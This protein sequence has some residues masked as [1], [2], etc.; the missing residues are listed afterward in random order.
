MMTLISLFIGAFLAAT[1]LPFSSEVMLLA[2]LTAGHIPVVILVGVAASGNILGSVVNWLLGRYLLHW[3]AHRWFPF[4][5]QQIENASKRF[6]R[7]GLWSLLFAFLP[8][9]GDPLTFIAGVLRVSFWP[10]L[11]LVGI[12]KT[13][14]YA[15]IA[16]AV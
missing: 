10:F 7:Y 3:R 13:A 15:M 2:S 9:I 6:N 5:E 11:L 12:G 8:V 14:R 1:L 16:L 4:S